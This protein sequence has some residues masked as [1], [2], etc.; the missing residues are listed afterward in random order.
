MRYAL[1]M[2]NRYYPSGGWQDLQGR[3]TS[4]EPLQAL[5]EQLLDSEQF[6]F[7]WWQ[8]VDLQENKIIEAGESNA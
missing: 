6:T 4:L 8:I 1:F 2:G 3:A 5:K 7:A